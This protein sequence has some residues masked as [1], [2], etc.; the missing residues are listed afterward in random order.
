M[1]TA[2]L[3]PASIAATAAM[4]SAASETTNP[5]R[6][7][8]RRMSSREPASSSTISTWIGSPAVLIS[9]NLLGV[10]ER[11]ELGQGDGALRAQ[12][13]DR[14]RQIGNVAVAGGGL[15]ETRDRRDIGG[16]KVG[17]GTLQ[18]VRGARHRFGVAVL[19]AVVHIG[20]QLRVVVAI[21]R[22]QTREQ[23]ILAVRVELAHGFDGGRVQ[24]DL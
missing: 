6:S 23:A 17:A 18:C 19:H 15:D 10:V 21:Q 5:L 14:A 2:L 16:A 22:D 7:S 20:E 8:A 4:P 13:G 9:G 24:R 11:F 12:L 1:S 3:S